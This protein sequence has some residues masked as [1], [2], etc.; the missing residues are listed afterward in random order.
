MR[1]RFGLIVILLLAL[2]ACGGPKST[3][4]NVV[5]IMIDQFRA[6]LMDAYGGILLLALTPT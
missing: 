1:S 6:D 2:I 5:F 4:P 3:P